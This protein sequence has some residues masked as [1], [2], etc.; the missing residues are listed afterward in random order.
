MKISVRPAV[1]AAAVLG[2]ACA[3]PQPK[4]APAAMTPPAKAAPAPAPVAAAAPDPAPAP[5]VAPKGPRHKFW[6]EVQSVD[7]GTIVV[8]SRGGHTRTFRVAAA[9]K[10]TKGGDETAV[11]VSDIA[12]GAHVRVVYAGDVAVAVHVMIV[13]G[14]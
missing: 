5:V 7:A 12:A 4:P 14:K 1:L 3:A 6:G 8:K 2:A 11:A 13:A 10:L 9:A